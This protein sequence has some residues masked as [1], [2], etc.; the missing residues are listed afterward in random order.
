MK[1]TF[2]ELLP[3]KTRIVENHGFHQLLN[4]KHPTYVVH[5]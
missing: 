5:P 2:F 3:P 1:R 4:K